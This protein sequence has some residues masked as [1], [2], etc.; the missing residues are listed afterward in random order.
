MQRGWTAEREGLDMREQTFTYT[1]F[2]LSEGDRAALKMPVGATLV[3]TNV[4]NCRC[5]GGTLNRCLGLEYVYN[6][7]EQPLTCTLP[8]KKVK[9]FYEDDDEGNRYYRG[10]V[11]TSDGS[12]QGY[13]LATS[14]VAL[15]GRRP[16]RD[17]MICALP[18]ESGERNFYY[19][20]SQM[21]KR[22]EDGVEILDPGEMRNNRAACVFHDRFFYSIGRAIVFTD[23]GNFEDFSVSAYGA[24][25]IE[26][27]EGYGNVLQMLVYQDAIL[28][29]KENMMLRFHAAG[30]ADDFRIEPMDYYGGKIMRNSAVRCGKYVLFLTEVGDVYRLYGT[31]FERL[32]EGVPKEF[33]FDDVNVTSDGERYFIANKNNVLVIEAEDGSKHLSYPVNGITDNNGMA[34]GEWN[35]HVCRIVPSGFL[36]DGVQPRFVAKGVA[37]K[38]RKEKLVKRLIFYGEGTVTVRFGSNG[39]TVERELTLSEYGAELI[40]GIKGKAFDFQISFTDSACVRK[41]DVE[42]S[43]LGGAE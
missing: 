41:I 43:E 18:S 37:V 23:A 22:F 7:D 6:P 9:L 2:A 36:P 27:L 3:G 1:G 39:H 4:E 28:L 24:G 8:A 25:R 15:M 17:I 13:E 31:R 16:N 21:I 33:C 38:D 19:L 30:A 20:S 32:V 42:F 29:F 14:D 34:V 35:Y 10:V 12:L 11:A 5:R 26:V 40:A